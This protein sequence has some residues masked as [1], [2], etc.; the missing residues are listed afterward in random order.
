MNG[1]INYT[2]GPEVQ[3]AL[4][5]LGRSEDIQFSPDQRRLA[6][7][8]FKQHRILLVD[9]EVRG[10]AGALQVHLPSCLMLTGPSLKLPHGLSFLDEDTIVVAN[11]AGDVVFYAIPHVGQGETRAELQV[12]HEL[13]AGPEHTVETPG[14]V[15]V[16]PLGEDLFELLVCNNY[17]NTVSRHVID[18][19]DQCRAVASSVL[20]RRGLTTPDGVTVDPTGRWIAISNHGEHALNL[21]QNTEQLHCDAQPE[22]E[23][24]GADYPHAACF[25]PDGRFLLLADAGSPYVC[26]YAAREQGWSGALQPTHK[27]RIMSDETFARGH[28]RP[29]EGG[30]KG[31]DV[32][33]S[34]RV[35]AITTEYQQLAFFDLGTILQEVEGAQPAEAPRAPAAAAKT[36]TRALLLAECARMDQL[37]RRDLKARLDHLH[38]SDSWRMTKPLRW[39][40]QRLRQLKRRA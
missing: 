12:L 21:Y 9:V 34:Q 17:A 36:D 19:A 40:G 5:E 28:V 26:I 30:A 29:D 6:V 14:S 1:A 16:R 18:R 35:L 37:H 11:R 13:E 23:A 2:A 39:L 24:R 32:D 33:R 10:D 3:A 27:V 15:Q 38:S 25:T 4:T 7:V 8:G 20:L 22:G 31:I